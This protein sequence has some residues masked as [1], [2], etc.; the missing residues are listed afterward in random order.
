MQK[1]RLGPGKAPRGKETL[2]GRYL[3]EIPT[4]R[5]TAHSSSLTLI[6]AVKVIHES[7]F[8]LTAGRCPNPGCQI[9]LRQTNGRKAISHRGS[10]AKGLVSRF[11]GP[12]LRRKL[13]TAQDD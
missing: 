2:S 1:V 6:Q 12:Q 11:L 9:R 3:S 7:S 5:P 8:H 13:P 10:P 4:L